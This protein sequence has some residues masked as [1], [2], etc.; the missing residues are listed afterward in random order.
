MRQSKAEGIGGKSGRGTHRRRQNRPRIP[1]GRRNFGDEL[2]RLEMVFTR[3]EMGVEGGV[4]RAIYRRA[5]SC[6]R[7]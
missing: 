1:A 7:G 3:D 2:Q 6:R 5:I 4:S